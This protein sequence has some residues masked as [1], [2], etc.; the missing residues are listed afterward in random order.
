M[1]ATTVPWGA[2]TAST[3]PISWMECSNPQVLFKTWPKTL[4]LKTTVLEE[5]WNDSDEP[6]IGVIT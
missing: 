2:L 3:P 6:G 4:K 1:D 5:M